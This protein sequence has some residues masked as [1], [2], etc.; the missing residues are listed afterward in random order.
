MLSCTGAIYMN[1]LIADVT[2][3]VLSP[4]AKGHYYVGLDCEEVNVL[5][6]DYLEKGLSLHTLR[7]WFTKY[8]L[9]SS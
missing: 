8:T 4:Y 9:L 2:A 1:V 3:I 6:P 7:K 5:S